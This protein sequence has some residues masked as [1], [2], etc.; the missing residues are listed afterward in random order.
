M[1]GMEE[2]DQEGQRGDSRDSYG[3]ALFKAGVLNG[4]VASNNLHHVL[5]F[6]YSLDD[7]LPLSNY[8]KYTGY[9][10]DMDKWEEFYK[11]YQLD[12]LKNFHYHSG[13]VPDFCYKNP[14]DVTLSLD[15]IPTLNYFQYENHMQSL[16]ACSSKY[17]IIYG[18]NFNA[19][20][21]AGKNHRRFTDWVDLYV[22]DRWRLV[23]SLMH[24]YAHTSESDF[25]IF[26][27]TKWEQDCGHALGTPG[28]EEEAALTY[29]WWL[30]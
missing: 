2:E 23:A 3:E 5:Q 14:A 28:R 19:Q 9:D 4:F 11:R 27:N 24:R 15:V 8:P 22:Q 25:Y 13:D 16:F 29:K 26:K 20:T 10:T 21:K 6:Q 1:P 17:V 18:S 30:P 12:P 7:T